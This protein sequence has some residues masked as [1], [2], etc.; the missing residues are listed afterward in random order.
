VNKVELFERHGLQL[1]I[2]HLSSP[3]CDV[4]VYVLN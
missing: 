2:N 3:D 1:L 4:Q